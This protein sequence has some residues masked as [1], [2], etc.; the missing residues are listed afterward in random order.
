MGEYIYDRN[1]KLPLTH[2]R[3]SWQGTGEDFQPEKYR[4]V[5]FKELFINGNAM[6]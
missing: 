5:I 1:A 2:E 4:A 6:G 3:P